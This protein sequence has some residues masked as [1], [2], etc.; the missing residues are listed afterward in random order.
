[1]K[2]Y[3]AAI[4]LCLVPGC[5]NI[6]PQQ[7]A[8]ISAVLT[9]ATTLGAVAASNNTT[10]EKLVGAGQLLCMLPGGPAAVVGV[11]VTGAPADYVQAVCNG[12]GG[13]PAALPSG[14]APA[15]LPVAVMTTSKPA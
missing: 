3:V 9:T 1:M 8:A 2:L 14:V 4:A 5:A 11:N 15:S 12:L 13:K 10:A 6:T 7:Q